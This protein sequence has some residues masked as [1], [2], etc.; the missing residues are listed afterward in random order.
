MPASNEYGHA[1]RSLQ[2]A[3]ILRGSDSNKVRE[4]FLMR[5]A[6]GARKTIY[7]DDIGCNRNQRAMKRADCLETTRKSQFLPPFRLYLF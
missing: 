2:S 1:A 4:P 3:G 7:T 6:F 5:M